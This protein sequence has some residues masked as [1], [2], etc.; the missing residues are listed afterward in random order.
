MVGGNKQIDFIPLSSLEGKHFIVKD[1]QRGYKWEEEQINALLKDIHNHNDGKYCLQPLIVEEKNEGIELIDGQQRI[2]TIY[3]LL[4][5]FDKGIFYSIDYQTRENTQQFLSKHTKLLC[6]SASSKIS[7]E[8]FAKKHPKFDN[9][10]I[11]H[12]QL[13]YSNICAW[14]SEKDDNYKKLF[15]D[16]L[17]HQVHVIWYD[18]RVNDKNQLAEEVFLNL[19]SGK[20]PL[21][22]SELIKALFILDIQKR[23]SP[24]I[25]KLKAAAL[26]AEW[27]IIENKLHDDTFWYF[28]CDHK[29][30][31]DSD[32]RIDLIIDLAN[33][34]SPTY[35]AWS[36]MDAYRKYEEIFLNGGQLD[37]DTVKNTYNKLNEWFEDKSLYH[38]AGF[39][40]VTG[41]KNLLDIINS[42]K[43]KTKIEFHE[44]LLKFIR[45]EFIKKITRD[46]VTHGKYDLDMITYQND[47]KSCE[48]ALVLLNIQYYL[49]NRSENKF[50]FNLYKSESWSVEHINPQNPKE[51]GTVGAI[52][53][54][55]T[56]FKTYFE[57]SGT[58]VKLVKEIAALLQ[59]LSLGAADKKLVDL[60][61]PANRIDKL[62]E[63]IANITESL[64]LHNISNLA[65]IDRVTNSTLGNKVFMEKRRLVVDLYYN[66]ENSAYIPECTKDV[67]TKNFSKD[68]TAISDGIFGLADMEDYKSYIVNQLKPYY[69]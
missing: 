40:V 29:V 14:F 62:D 28:I 2:T 53:K 30:Y 16:K 37:W 34:I 59:I 69:S 10:D 56:S 26:A 13:V 60:K 6:D 11:F 65:L 4:L 27:D 8:D 39:L 41:I 38:Y 46:G 35:K 47:K 67:F 15:L 51:F 52:I 45:D 33:A 24:D 1:Y 50:P 63:V 66:G 54:W 68:D 32:T 36:P 61:L 43:G 55:L 17:L 44:A 19:N 64:D 7:W 5:Y 48:N 22:S 31:E 49:N 12:L 58:E 42:S 3:L 21:T 20:I 25:A 57:K 9:V 18:I 23:F